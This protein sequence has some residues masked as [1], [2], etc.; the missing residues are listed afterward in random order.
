[1][2]KNAVKFHL[3]QK[4]NIKITR[5]TPYYLKRIRKDDMIM[6]NEKGFIQTTLNKK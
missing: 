2:S 4:Q 5:L 1:M 3:N 6:L